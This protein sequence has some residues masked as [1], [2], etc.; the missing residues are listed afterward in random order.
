ME[1]ELALEKET[2]SEQKMAAVSLEAYVGNESPGQDDD[3][4]QAE[5]FPETIGLISST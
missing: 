3:N 4:F 1:A 2:L 5:D